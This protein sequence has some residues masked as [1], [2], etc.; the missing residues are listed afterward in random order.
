[1]SSILFLIGGFVLGI[2]SWFVPDLERANAITWS[3]LFFI[4]SKLW[5][6]KNEL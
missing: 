4:L 6:K 3:I 5:E 2:S 1:M